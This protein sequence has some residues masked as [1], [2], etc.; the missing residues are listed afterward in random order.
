MLNQDTKNIQENVAKYCLGEELKDVQA[1]RPKRLAHY[2]RLIN[3]IITDALENSFPITKDQLSDENWNLMVEEFITEHKCKNPQLFLMP[4]ELIDFAIQK[5]YPEKF[6]VNYLIDLLKFEWVEVEVHSAEDIE[7]GDFKMQKDILNDPIY[8]SPYTQILHLNYPLHALKETNISERKGD[9]FYMIYR[10][11][12]GT[13]QYIQLNAL[14]TQIAFTLME[15]D[16]SFHELMNDMLK[17]EKQSLKEIVVPQ[18]ARFIEKLK[19]LGI[20][21]G[22]REKNY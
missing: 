14:T 11:P 1:V 2:K 21:L 3:S 10:Q 15:S 22:I 13:V 16:Y 17:N 5:K 20:I 19:N 7:F 6:E 4:G 8:F 9:F 12:N 18:A